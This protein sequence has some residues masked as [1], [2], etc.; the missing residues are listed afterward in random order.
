M[1]ITRHR[2]EMSAID[3]IELAKVYENVTSR[4]CFSS[5]KLLDYAAELEDLK[6]TGSCRAAIE[7]HRSQN[8]LIE[9]K[10]IA[11]DN[12]MK[13]QE[14]AMKSQE[15]AKEV[16]QRCQKT[17]SDQSAVIEDLRHDMLAIKTCQREMNLTESLQD[18]LEQ[19]KTVMADKPDLDN[20]IRKQGE[21]IFKQSLVISGLLARLGARP[22]DK[23]PEVMAPLDKRCWQGTVMEESPLAACVQD[24]EGQEWILLQRRGQFGNGEDYFAKTFTE[25]Q[26]GFTSNEE[27]WVGLNVMA[28]ITAFHTWELWI[29]LTTWGNQFYPAKKLNAF[30]KKFKV[31]SGPGYKLTVTSPDNIR[32]TLDTRSISHSNG[33][34]FSATD[35]DQ[36]THSKKH[37]AKSYGNA[38]W[39]FGSCTHSNLN[40]K[41][42]PRLTV[43]INGIGWWYT[44]EGM[45]KNWYSFAESKI[46]IRKLN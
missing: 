18:L 29:E 21:V 19:Q 30:Y 37:C 28:D 20:T 40:G 34:K 12:V 39:W 9:A 22:E 14:V 24:A 31:G 35:L 33:N 7:L 46:A 23:E 2:D 42:F 44:A 27:L 11:F 25:Y 38:G 45:D 1:F 32:S 10:Q 3:I 41:N 17:R 43:D 4:S 8:E 6:Y 26:E 36:D 13:S 5:Q 15:V 16:A